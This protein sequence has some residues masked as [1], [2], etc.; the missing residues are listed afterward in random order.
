MG[1][2]LTH[3]G[4]TNVW[5]TVVVEGGHRELSVERHDCVAEADRVVE[6]VCVAAAQAVR[7]G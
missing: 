2:E 6:R 4:T 1:S 3:R 5:L 7:D